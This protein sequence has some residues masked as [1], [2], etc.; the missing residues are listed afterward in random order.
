MGGNT[1]IHQYNGSLSVLLA[2]NYPEYEWL[3]WKFEKCPRNYWEDLKNQRKFADWAGKQLNIKEMSD[4]YNVKNKVTL[5][6]ITIFRNRNQYLR[7]QAN[8]LELYTTIH[9][10]IFCPLFILTTI[11]CHG[12]LMFALV[13][14]GPT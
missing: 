3:P 13:T 2:E 14:I 12:N 10:L 7:K 4:W 1:L 11:G 9:F 6:Q 8:C 5:P